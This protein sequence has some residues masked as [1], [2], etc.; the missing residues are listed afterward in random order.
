MKKTITFLSR[1]AAVM[2]L[3]MMLTAT[4][5]WADGISYLDATGTQQSCTTYTTVES[6]STSWNSGWCVVNSNTTISDRITVSGTVN[7]ILTNNATLTASKGI[8]VGSDATLNIY[9][10]TDDEATM[11]ALVASGANDNHQYNAGI[12]GVENADAGMITINGGKINA[13]GNVGAGIG[14]GGGTSTV[15]TITINGGIVTAQDGSGYGAGIGG[16]GIQGKASTINLNGGIINAA[17]IGSGNFGGD[18]I[19]TVNISDGIRK[20]VATPVQGGACIG[21]GKSASGSVTVNFI[22]GGNIVTGDDKDA[23]FYDTDEGS[24][25]QIRTKALNHTVSMSDDLKAHITVSTELAITGETVTLTLGTAVDASTLKVNDGTSDLTLTDAGNRNYTFTMPAGNVTVTATLLQTYSVNLPAN[26]EIV[27]ATTTAD[28]DGKYIS[29]TVVTFKASFSYTASNVSDGANTLTADDSGNYSVTVGTADITV[30]ATIEHSSNIDLSQAP[31]DFTIVDGDV[32]T[33]STSHTV[34]IADGANITLKNSTITGGIVCNGTATITLVGTNSVTG[35]SR[36]LSDPNNTYNSAGIQIGGEGTTLTIR[37]NGSLTA[38]GGSLS[39]GIGVRSALSHYNE[40]D[41]SGGNIVIEGGNIVAQ[42]SGSGAAG[43]GTGCTFARISSIGTITIKGGTV[44]ATGGTDANGIGNGDAYG[45][46]GTSSVGTITFYDSIDLIDASSISDFGSVV[47]MHGET[48][49]TASKTD[50]F[51]IV[52]DGDRRVIEPKDD[53]DYTIT[54][55]NGI[56][57][58]TL[59]GAA[60]AKYTEKVTITATPDFGY[61]LSRLVVK[62]AQ[63]NDVA[64]TG[65]SFFMPKSNVT[66]SA[67][68]EQGTH[69]TTEFKWFYLTGSKPEDIVLETIYDGVTTVNIQNSEMS[70]QIRKYEDE[71]NYQYFLLDND[72]YEANIP[73]AGGT[74]VFPENDNGTSFSI[75]N[76]DETGYYD[77]TMTDVG[78]GKWNVS[79]LKTAG[80]MDVVPDQTYTGSEITPEPLVLAGSL[81]L[82]KGTDYVYSYENNEN[83]G[84]AKVIATFQGDYASLGYVEK[85]FTIVYPT[86]TTSYVDASGTLHE[87]VEAVPLDNTMT[88]ISAGW[89]VVNSD[90]TFSGNLSTNADGEVNIILCDGATLTANNITPIGNSD[91]LRIYGQSQSTGTANISGRIEASSSL[92]IYGGTINAAGNIMCRQSGVGIY[93][94]NVTAADID[95]FRGLNF[96]GGTITASSLTVD[97][98]D[99]TLGGATVTAGSYN[100]T[101]GNVTILTGITYYDGTGASYTAG[102][103]SA[104]QISAIRGKILR[105]YDYR[106]G[107]C[108]KDDLNVIWALNGTSPNYTLTISGT[109]AM[110][111]Y[112]APDAQP[113]KDYRSSIASVVI[114]DG[115]TSIGNMAFEGCNNAN[116]TSV[117][118]PASVTSIGDFAFGYCT[119][120]ASVTIPVASLTYYGVSAFDN[121]ADGL[122]IYV[123]GSA[124]ST[125]KAETN[126]SAYKDNFVGVYTLTYDLAGGTLP[127]G[128]SNPESYTAEDKNFLLNNPTKEGYA[129]AG[130]KYD[131]TEGNNTLNYTEVFVEVV[132]F[133]EQDLSFTATWVAEDETH[134]DLAKCRAEVDNPLYRGGSGNYVGYYYENGNGIKVYDGD[135]LLTYYHYDSEKGEF[136]GDYSYFMLVSLDGGNCDDMGEHC[137]VLLTGKGNYVGGL[138]ADVV[139]VANSVNGKWGDLKWAY[140]NGTLTISRKDGVTEDVVMDPMSSTGEGYDSWLGI[141]SGIF[142]IVFEE[143]V[144][145]IAE[146]AFGYVGDGLHHYSNLATIS[147]P[148]SLTEIGANAFAHCDGLTVDLDDILAKNITLGNNAFYQIGCLAGSLANMANNATKIALLDQAISNNITLKD[149]TLYKDGDWN[150]LCLPFALGN[151]MADEG[152]HFDGT[153]LEGATVMQLSAVSSGLSSGGEL[154]LT[155]INAL[156]IEAGKPYIVKWASADNLVNPVFNGVNII[157]TE[158]TPV[159]FEFEGNSAN[160]QFVGNYNPKEITEATNR[161]NIVVLA[162]G[163]KLGY[164]TTDRTIANG[165]ALGAFRAYFYIPEK[166][167]TTGASSFVLNFGDEETTTGIVDNKRETITNNH[168][169]SLDGRKLDGKPTQKGLYIVN[170]RKVVIK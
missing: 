18:C 40:S 43:I 161:N 170:G 53:T 32:L 49:V 147:L 8:T 67:E 119:Y 116:L 115:V 52:E 156:S 74:G 45:E 101:D 155:F 28:G 137:R 117:T 26:M 160:C 136:V 85:E 30:T 17:G 95:G 93:G 127:A 158:P 131:Y 105:T 128:K 79:I 23:V 35:L 59:T 99:I 130:W 133:G 33:G 56:E 145:T 73:Y 37:G 113:W 81:S 29:G 76:Y 91:Y 16:G 63:N 152:H 112:G 36:N 58:G 65:N 39:A 162:G 106:G 97:H 54:I 61:R 7:L 27:S 47:Y 10:Q 122:K 132:P 60:T 146:T 2:L 110:K 87:N 70:Y 42:T 5:A 38:T 50:Y 96:T 124:L 6:S 20:I 68:F 34:T 150:T 66:V 71:Y 164:T 24:E 1:R 72:T 14:S 84:T 149:R 13:T 100:V 11:G 86:V 126:W 44:T 48:D 78:N 94:G 168:W 167:G 82:T 51:A 102:N 90:V 98:G 134:K 107:T 88:T 120:L 163:N 19:I 165:K 4:A 69:G 25:R 139:I 83:V 9:A 159:E 108:G 135:K 154:T 138:S 3:V 125:Y 21:K 31:S 169:Y 75:P 92:Q 141:G 104:D 129:F 109:G 111:D 166:D 103:L 41:V 142:S 144:K 151:A 140:D 143:G 57:H 77:I 46:G 118:I 153:L 22:S 114:E 64:S 62:D 157:N 121:T 123:P 12:G 80:Q 15:G 89:Y 148:S 55:A